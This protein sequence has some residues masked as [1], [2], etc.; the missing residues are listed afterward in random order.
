MLRVLLNEAKVVGLLVNF[1]K[2]KYINLTRSM[3]N[4]KTCEVGEIFIGKFEGCG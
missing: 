1:D 3:E 4:K 2:T